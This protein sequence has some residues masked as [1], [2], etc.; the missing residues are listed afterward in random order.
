MSRIR[1]HHSEESFQAIGMLDGLLGKRGQNPLAALQSPLWI[2][3]PTLASANWLKKELLKSGALLLNVRFITPPTLRK[4]FEGMVPDQ[5]TVLSSGECKLLARTFLRG[6]NR[7]GLASA[8]QLIIETV[9]MFLRSGRGVLPEDPGLSNLLTGFSHV[10]ER[11]GYALSENVDARLATLS[12]V[13]TVEPFDLILYGFGPRYWDEWKLI[14]AA[15]QFAREA[16]IFLTFPRVVAEKPGLWWLSSWEEI[17]SEDSSVDYPSSGGFTDELELE[18]FKQIAEFISGNY[19]TGAVGQ[20][21]LFQSID[22]NPAGSEPVVF[23]VVRDQWDESRM[24]AAQVLEWFSLGTEAPRIGII[25]S[26]NA[27]LAHEIHS[28]FK[29]WG[30][31]CR[32]E[33]GVPRAMSRSQELWSIWLRLLGG[34]LRAGDFLGF[35]RIAGESLCRCLETPFTKI[36]DIESFL[37][38][39]FGQLLSDRLRVIYA[40]AA[41]RSKMPLVLRKFLTR[42]IVEWELPEQGEFDDCRKKTI[43][44]L[45]FLQELHPDSAFQ[46]K[47]SEIIQFL[48]CFER[49]GL[50]TL[51]RDDLIS[52]LADYA[53]AEL[54]SVEGDPFA[55]VTITTPERAESQ[56]WDYLFLAGLYEGLWPRPPR[57]HPIITDE[58]CEKLNFSAQKQ[59][60]SGEGQY[61]FPS[62]RSALLSSQ[63]RRMLDREQF[64]NLVASARKQIACSTARTDRVNN[65]QPVSASEFF[66]RVYSSVKGGILDGK[67]LDA[68]LAKTDSWAEKFH[69]YFPGA[70]DAAQVPDKAITHVRV[71]YDRR[72]NEDLPFDEYS[73]ALRE[74]PEEMVV[75]SAKDW[76]AVRQTPAKMWYQWLG[77]KVMGKAFDLDSGLPLF[78]GSL[79]HA[80]IQQILAVS[81]DE[82]LALRKLRRI[83]PNAVGASARQTLERLRKSYEDGGVTFPV[84]WEY[85]LTRLEWAASRTLKTLESLLAGK[86]FG[87]EIKK[88]SRSQLIT[89]T[90]QNAQLKSYGKTDLLI[91]DTA[92]PVASQTLQ[93]I[94]FKTSTS[95]TSFGNARNASLLK[96]G[97]YLQVA[98]YGLF[99]HQEQ[100][101]GTMSWSV[102]NPFFGEGPDNSMLEV[103]QKAGSLFKVLESVQM[104]G[105]FGQLEVMDEDFGIPAELPTACLPVEKAILK[106]RWDK[107]FGTSEEEEGAD[108]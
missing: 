32:N 48:E 94:D 1:L 44:A 12:Q 3:C 82:A 97:D 66:Q 57:S 91:S 107:T 13:C 99:Y 17:A 47:T 9:Q 25:L 51:Y 86:Y 85:E 95:Q 87:S 2:A 64:L 70:L 93:V 37:S 8:P 74:C 108:E 63:A 19:P 16:D 96:S 73:Y 75:F 11:G 71:I 50:T 78:R 49:S 27:P 30:I 43:S 10:M 20:G 46:E 89:V 5:P 34:E 52:Y 45:G 81:S 29:R 58:L 98:L 80:W 7:P 88:G 35:Y 23:H 92:D 106:K 76:Q 59:S 26:N 6:S 79:Y 22:R 42:W 24:I 36:Q 54:E 103:E 15:A 100:K 28:H 101:D 38:D 84:Q 72:R 105:I 21:D 77:L 62:D 14:S 56:S 55:Y 102:Y 69:S 83:D 90:V 41:L 67:T 4:L 53:V 18:R 68:L 40:D 60:R 104:K 39:A 61:Y 65:N 31:P 33:Y